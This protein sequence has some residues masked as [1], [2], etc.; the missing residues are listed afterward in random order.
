MKKYFQGNKPAFL[1]QSPNK[2]YYPF[3]KEQSF[4]SGQPKPV[5]SKQMNYDKYEFPI[6]RLPDPKKLR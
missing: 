2:N 1:F 3:T 4:L 6:F 5:S